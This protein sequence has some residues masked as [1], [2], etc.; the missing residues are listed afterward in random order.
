MVA[1]VEPIV[2]VGSGIAN[3]MFFVSWW[4]TRSGIVLLCTPQDRLVKERELSS[5]QLYLQ[6]RA[7]TITRTESR[8]KIIRAS[9]PFPSALAE[10]L[11]RSQ[12]SLNSIDEGR[13]S[14]RCDVAYVPYRDTNTKQLLDQI[15]VRGE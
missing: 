10:A 9:R 5:P 6:S 2:R 1:A 15:N 14:E 13:R 12:A 4:C 7:E 3:V 11:R 8:G